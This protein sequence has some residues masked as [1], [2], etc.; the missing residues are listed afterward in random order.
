MIKPEQLRIGNFVYD[1]FKEVHRVESISSDA[2]KNWSKEPNVILSK[3]NGL[4]GFYQ[5]DEIEPI[6][7]SEEWL[8]KFGFKKDTYE[9]GTWIH[10]KF[11]IYKSRE[12]DVY[13]RQ[14]WAYNE[15][16]ANVGWNVLDE[17][18]EIKF[19][20]ELQNYF[21]IISREE[22]TLNEEK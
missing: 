4:K 5:S 7:L 21:Y 17:E 6:P 20:H 12:E 9:E 11:C 10:G 15:G 2:Y 16:I 1:D 22:L 8:L 19:L 13:W 18:K 14:I 3:I